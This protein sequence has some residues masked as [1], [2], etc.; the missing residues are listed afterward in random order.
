M[1]QRDALRGEL[2]IQW[3]EDGRIM[4]NLPNDP[5]IAYFMLHVAE[6]E[7]QE[8]MMARKAETLHAAQR[9]AVPKD[10]ARAPQNWGT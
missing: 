4:F 7:L 8:R 5:S 2:T 10:G 3:Y 6:D 1:Q 9:L